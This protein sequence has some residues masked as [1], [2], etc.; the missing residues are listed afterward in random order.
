MPRTLL[1]VGGRDE[2]GQERSLVGHFQQSAISAVGFGGW[3][4]PVLQVAVDGVV[5][6][7]VP[8]TARQHVHVH[9]RY[10][11]AHATQNSVRSKATR[12]RWG[13]ATTY[14]RTGPRQRHPGSRWSARP[15]SMPFPG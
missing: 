14:A 9:V 13:W 5:G 2:G 3:G 1:R 4:C 10:P 8:G 7:K 15:R 12:G 11:V 6:L